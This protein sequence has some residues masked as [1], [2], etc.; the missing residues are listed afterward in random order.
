MEVSCNSKIVLWGQLT[1]GW[2]LKYSVYCPDGHG[3]SLHL[4]LARA[5]GPF[6]FV[7]SLLELES[8]PTT[9]D[10]R[11]INIKSVIEGRGTMLMLV[12][13]P[14]GGA[15]KSVRYV[16]K[17]VVKHNLEKSWHVNFQ[18]HKN[19]EVRKDAKGYGPS[20]HERLP[21]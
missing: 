2:H 7:V 13:D 12:Y 8:L 21:T 4:L 17:I 1:D 20:S 15:K 11:N 5:P 3:P 9:G 6:A 16:T 19:I 18:Q 10:M 14:L